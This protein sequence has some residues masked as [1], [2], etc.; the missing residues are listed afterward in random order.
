MWSNE[1]MKSHINGDSKLQILSDEFKFDDFNLANDTNINCSLISQNNVDF[2]DIINDK[3]NYNKLELKLSLTGAYILELIN[4]IENNIIG[5]IVC[6][7]CGLYLKDVGKVNSDLTTHLIVKPEFRN[8]RYA[9]SLILSAMKIMFERN[10]KFGYHWIENKKT[11]FAIESYFWYR[12]LS[13]SKIIGKGYETIKNESYHIP[14]IDLNVEFN[15]TV[16]QDFISIKS[17]SKIRLLP[18]EE[19]LKLLNNVIN[20]YSIKFDDKIIGIIGYRDFNIVKP[21]KKIINACQLCY[22]DCTFGYQD[23]VFTALLHHLKNLNYCAIHGV[24]MSNLELLIE[25]MKFTIVNVVYLDF[26]N[27]SHPNLQKNEIALLYV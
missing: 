6:L 24:L 7:P 25:T 14:K 17:G 15:K 23:K 13:L 2:L 26:F 12:I 5:Q 22:F 3:G 4:S 19:Q 16:R 1:K 27:L 20:F 18:D 11:E 10:I 21:D 8:K 9:E